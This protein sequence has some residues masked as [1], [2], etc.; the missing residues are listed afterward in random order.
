MTFRRLGCSVFP[1][2]PARGWVDLN[3][4]VNKMRVYPEPIILIR[5]IRQFSAKSQ[6][7]MDIIYSCPIQMGFSEDFRGQT[8]KTSHGWSSF[9]HIFHGNF[10]GATAPHFHTRLFF[11]AQTLVC[12]LPCEC[13]MPCGGSRNG[14]RSRTCRRSVSGGSHR[15]ISEENWWIFGGFGNHWQ[16]G[17]R[18]CL[19]YFEVFFWESANIFGNLRG[20]DP[21]RTL[22]TSLRWGAIKRHR[23]LMFFLL[24]SNIIFDI[25]KM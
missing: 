19:M 3:G 1:I 12:R 14:A 9:C 21:V 23:L 6:C 20:F 10:M 15:G 25:Q 13:W 16:I 5:W 2:P 11:C 8:T 4:F 7:S 24:V 17:W 22:E 18:R